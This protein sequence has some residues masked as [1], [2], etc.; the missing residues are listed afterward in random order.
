MLGGDDTDVPCGIVTAEVTW[1]NGRLKQR[2]KETET[3]ND[4][5]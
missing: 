2:V 4:A 5:G 1:S 3:E